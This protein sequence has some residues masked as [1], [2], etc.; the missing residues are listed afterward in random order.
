MKKSPEP[1]KEV[2]EI[3]LTKFDVDKYLFADRQLFLTNTIDM[4]SS[5]RLIK[6][7]IALD[8][9]S[10]K[11]ILLWI[12]SGGGSITAGL[13]IIDTIKRI[14]TPVVSI[15][16]GMACSMAGIISV[17]ADRR[18]ITANSIWMAHDGH[19]YVDDYF[20]KV[21]A[22]TKNFLKPLEQKI[23]KILKKH[24]KLTDEELRKARNGEL[25]VNAKRCKAKGIVDG[26]C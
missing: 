5:N 21:F 1:E 25:W 20:T 16:N 10:N 14:Q 18:L 15:V 17:C 9:L 3:D 26:I 24:T 2:K 6:Q 11:P 12:N 22:R 19:T 8:R 13:A 4:E 23:L 7:L